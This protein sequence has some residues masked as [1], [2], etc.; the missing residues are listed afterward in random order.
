MRTE[1]PLNKRQ[2]LAAMND[3]EVTYLNKLYVALGGKGRIPARIANQIRGLLPHI[4]ELLD[5]NK[6]IL[7]LRQSK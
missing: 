1:A 6:T 5:A 7:R 3:P 4:M 2:I